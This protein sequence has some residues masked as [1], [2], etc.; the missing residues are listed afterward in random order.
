M[1]REN[2]GNYLEANTP[3]YEFVNRLSC[4]NKEMGNYNTL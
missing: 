3:V 4:Y 2:K 1:Q